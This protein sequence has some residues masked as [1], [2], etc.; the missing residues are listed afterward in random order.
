MSIA[1]SPAESS[2]LQTTPATQKEGFLTALQEVGDFSLPSSRKEGSTLC[3]ESPTSLKMLILQKGIKISKASN[4]LSSTHSSNNKK[5][6]Y[7]N[8]ATGTNSSIFS[9]KNLSPT[10]KSVKTCHSRAVEDNSKVETKSRSRLQEVLSSSD[11]GSK[12]V[13]KSKSSSQS[14]S[15]DSDSGCSCVEGLLRNRSQ[16][17]LSPLPNSGIPRAD[18]QVQEASFSYSSDYEFSFEYLKE[19]R[20]QKGLSEDMILEGQDGGDTVN[21]VKNSDPSSVL[22]SGSNKNLANTT[23]VCIQKSAR[24][25]GAP[26]CSSLKRLNSA[27]KIQN[28]WYSSKSLC[29]SLQRLA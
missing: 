13:L 7:L 2:Y 8:L 1:P 3:K 15:G 9:E 10:R 5:S 27:G 21:R 28:S 16:A 14:K 20:D 24:K 17:S 19:D 23:R 6:G 12:S 26:Q 25:I 22:F 18:K 29:G 11:E 4:L